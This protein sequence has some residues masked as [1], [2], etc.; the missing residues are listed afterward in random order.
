[1]NIIPNC[2]FKLFFMFLGISHG[3]SSDH[4]T[5]NCLKSFLI[6]GNQYVLLCKYKQENYIY[7]LKSRFLFIQSH[8]VCA[9]CL[10]LILLFL[11]PVKYLLSEW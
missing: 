9:F 4:N 6:N 5:F 11:F 2:T 10:C 3:Q 8:I 1:M 7:Y